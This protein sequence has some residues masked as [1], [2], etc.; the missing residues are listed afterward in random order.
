[1]G[2][3]HLWRSCCR[4]LERLAW[5]GL[6]EKEQLELLS[7]SQQ[8][9]YSMN[10]LTS[11]HFMNSCPLKEVDFYNEDCLGNLHFNMKAL[12]SF[13]KSKWYLYITKNKSQAIRKE[14]TKSSLE[15]VH[16]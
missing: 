10:R 12:F 5:E 4:K 15:A 13:K 11:F 6:G 8:T 9:L 7:P 14:S 2:E 3:G 1:M 16:P